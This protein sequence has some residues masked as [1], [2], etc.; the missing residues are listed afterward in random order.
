MAKK[1]EKSLAKDFKKNFNVDQSGI[2]LGYEAHYKRFL[3]V[4]KKRY[5]GV[6][7]DKEEKLMGLE[8][9]KRDTLPIVEK[10]QRKLLDMLLYGDET[11]EEIKKWLE[12]KRK[13][14]ARNK[15]KLEQITFQKRL[16]KEIEEYGQVS[17]KTGRKVPIPAHVKVA[18]WL[19]AQLSGRTDDKIN[20]FSQGA[21]IPYYVIQSKK[22]IV[23][24]HPSQFD[25]TYDIDY[26]WSRIISPSLERIM[27]AAFPESKLEWEDVEDS[28]NNGKDN[29]SKKSTKSKDKEGN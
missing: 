7:K 15:L 8:V 24:Q 26:Y 16:S 2:K 13:F 29:I 17:K 20:L 5:V 22:G 27:S 18:I 28:E 4:D 1:V 12:T 3:L 19:K 10:W 23:A 9:K 21:Y 14:V 6:T 25:G 11:E